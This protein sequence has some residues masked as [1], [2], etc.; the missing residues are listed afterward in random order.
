MG[1]LSFRLWAARRRKVLFPFMLIVTTIHPS[2]SY[3]LANGVQF[4]KT[5]FCSVFSLHVRF[6]EFR[7]NVPSD[8][9]T[10]G[11]LDSQG[12]KYRLII[13]KGSGRAVVFNS[14]D[15]A[16]CIGKI[17]FTRSY[18]ADTSATSGPSKKSVRPDFARRLHIERNRSPN[19]FYIYFVGKPGVTLNGIDD[20]L[21][22]VKIGNF[23]VLNTKKRRRLLYRDVLGISGRFTRGVRGFFCGYCGKARL[24]GR[25]FGIP[26]GPGSVDQSKGYQNS[27]DSGGNHS[28]PPASIHRSGRLRREILSGHVTFAGY[29]RF[30]GGFLS[31]LFGTLLTGR[32]IF[33]AVQN[34]GALAFGFS[35]LGLVMIVVGLAILVN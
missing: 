9:K 18:G 19:V 12:K 22:F 29:V 21:P 35:A 15:S 17:G 34:R 14:C 13:A 11:K 8:P 31:M 32:G 2:H 4:K 27:G 25:V 24:M 10:I 20:R 6:A 28:D 16:D 1:W 26:K 3:G 5:G 30:I 23:N 33:E 7:L